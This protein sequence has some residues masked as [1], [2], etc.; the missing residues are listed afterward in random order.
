MGIGLKFC[1]HGFFFPEVVSPIFRA[2]RS[3]LHQVF[4]QRG[5]A[6]DSRSC[7]LQVPWRRHGD[8]WYGDVGAFRF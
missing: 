2:F 4:M 8:A 7:V 3:K 6:H 1:S 5:H